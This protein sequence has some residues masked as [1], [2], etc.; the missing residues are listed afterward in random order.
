L[1][2]SRNATTTWGIKWGRPMLD[3]AQESHKSGVAR[4]HMDVARLRGMS[5]FGHVS[6]SCKR[7]Y[8][9]DW[10]DHGTLGSWQIMMTRVRGQLLWVIIL[11]CCLLLISS[12]RQRGK[13]KALRRCVQ[14][15][16]NEK[17]LDPDKITH[18]T[19]TGIIELSRITKKL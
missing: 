9:G 1:W 11:R 10:W 2:L 16:N 18:L 12:L 7:K 17:A 8:L 6:C 5:R 15:N 3:W 13:S 14:K 4:P 19:L